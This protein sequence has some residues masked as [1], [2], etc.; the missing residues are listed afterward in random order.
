MFC[1]KG[2]KRGGVC[3]YAVQFGWKH[4]GFWKEGGGEGG[5][6]RGETEGERTG[7]KI[8]EE[9]RREVEIEGEIRRVGV[10]VG[11]REAVGR[12]RGEGKKA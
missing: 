6:G 8:G 9:N 7:G 11:A 5:G 12:K 3:M 4:C 2:I 1:D 10:G